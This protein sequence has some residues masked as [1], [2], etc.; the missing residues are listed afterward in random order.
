MEK[1]S[2]ID[3]ILYCCVCHYYN[4]LAAAVILFC[5][6]CCI[7][8]NFKKYTDMYFFASICKKVK[9]GKV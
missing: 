8:V 3:N 4:N 9:I 2:V 7:I 5:T 1:A 6:L